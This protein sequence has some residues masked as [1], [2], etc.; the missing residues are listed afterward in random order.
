VGKEPWEY[1]AFSDGALAVEMLARRGYEP[2]AEGVL[3]PS[4]W[5]DDPERRC[6]CGAR[7]SPHRTRCRPCLSSATEG[8]NDA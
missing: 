4:S 6:E 3:R 2:D 7:K 5:K 8:T 1:V